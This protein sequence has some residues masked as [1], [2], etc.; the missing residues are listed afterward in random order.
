[1]SE[2]KYQTCAANHS[3]FEQIKHKYL[4]PEAKNFREAPVDETVVAEN[5]DRIENVDKFLKGVCK[6]RDGLMSLSKD[7]LIFSKSSA[8]NLKKA[9][10]VDQTNSQKSW[11]EA[12]ENIVGLLVI[13]AG[14]IGI[15]WVLFRSGRRPPPSDRGQGGGPRGGEPL[16]K[17]KR[18]KPV[19]VHSTEKPKLR[20]VDGTRPRAL[21]NEYG[22]TGYCEPSGTYVEYGRR[23]AIEEYHYSNTLRAQWRFAVAPLAIPLAAIAFATGIGEVAIGAGATTALAT[24]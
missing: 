17:P 13:G 22:N 8:E 4:D 23:W 1:M 6:N 10:N 20:I 5:I 12:I 16:P 7:A 2:I 3:G 11:P 15:P 24:G 21:L 18:E 19:N 14:G 9:Y